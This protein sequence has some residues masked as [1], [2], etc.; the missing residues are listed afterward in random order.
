MPWY[1]YQRGGWQLAILA[2]N[3]KDADVYAKRDDPRLKFVSEYTPA[4]TQNFN[5][6]TAAVTPEWKEKYSDK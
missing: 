3:R 1:L 2:I 6:V 5:T 4:H